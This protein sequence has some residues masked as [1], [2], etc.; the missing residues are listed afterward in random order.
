[1]PQIEVKFDIDQNGILNVSAADK[2]TGRSQS[3]TI[4]ASTKMS[5]ADIEQKIR[6]AEMNAEED[7]RFKELI[8]VKNQGE[9]LIYQTE[10]LMKENEAVIG[11]LKE[12]IN[13]KLADLHAAMATDD[14]T[15]IK[16]TT[17]A[18]Q[19]ALHE[20]S[21]RMYGQQEQ[22]QPQGPPPGGMGNQPPGTTY[23]HEGKTEDEI[24]EER[25]RRATGQDDGVVDAEYD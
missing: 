4:T 2:G 11:D 3:I 18:L 15:S 23:G 19:T 8:D 20:V 10:K 25:F 17:E 6:E 16:E 22:G 24:E 14:I 7:D 13:R 21:S 1:M 5:D 12:N 9:A